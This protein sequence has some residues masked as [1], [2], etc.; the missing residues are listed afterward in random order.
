MRQA[1][2]IATDRYQD[3]GYQALR[4]PAGDV[5][6]LRSALAEYGSFEV[7]EPLVNRDESSLRVELEDFFDG[8]AY[9][10]LLLLYLSGH[11]ELRGGRL[12]FAT[13]TTRRDK[14]R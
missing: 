6:A 2:L 8:A 7:R 3:P 5:K 13:A 1:L 12:Y 14:L 9:D 10:D 11:G 4:A